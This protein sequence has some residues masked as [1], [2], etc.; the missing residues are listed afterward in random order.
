MPRPTPRFFRLFIDDYLRDAEE[1]SLLQHGAYLRLMLWYYGR[2]KAIPNDLPRVYARCGAASREE[3]AAVESVLADF[4]AL[5]EGV[6]THKRIDEEL[7]HWT[8]RS[9]AAQQSSKL[10][11]SNANKIKGRANAN[12]LRPNEGSRHSEGQSAAS[13]E[14]LSKNVNQINLPTDANALR[15]Q[16]ERNPNQNKNKETPICSPVGERVDAAFDAF[17]KAYPRKVGKQAALKAWRKLRPGPELAER[18]LEAVAAQKRG[19]AWRRDG[20]QFIPH[21]TTWLNQ[22]RWDDEPPELPARARGVAI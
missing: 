9:A 5:E 6:W 21:P 8:Q 2:A 15:T 13:S 11:W 22:G 12:A 1:L 16:C 3:K 7:K 4:F 17:W 14:H 18:I 19:E 20:G 10:R